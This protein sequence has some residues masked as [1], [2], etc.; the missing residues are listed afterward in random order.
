MTPSARPQ[1]GFT[2]VEAIVATAIVATAIVALAH[3]FTIGATQA[4]RTRSA[5]LAI[6]AAQGKLRQLQA[7]TWSYGA[8]A[9]ELAL[10]PPRALLENASGY[11][12]YLDR[13]TSVLDAS[14]RD[15]ASFFR[16]W[17]IRPLNSTD[18]DTLV[19]QVCVYGSPNADPPGACVASIRTRR[20]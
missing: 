14:E 10:S 1:N 2:L 3:L 6:T 18:P 4:L 16:R 5:L 7:M 11:V 19:L 17:A 15:R 9:P 20:P 13:A 12:E 8:E